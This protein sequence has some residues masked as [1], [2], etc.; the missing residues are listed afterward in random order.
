[1]ALLSCW[2][3]RP[4]SVR[5]QV[6]DTPLETSTRN[7]ASYMYDLANAVRWKFVPLCWRANEA[8]STSECECESE[9][10]G[11]RA[12]NTHRVLED[13]L[14]SQFVRGFGCGKSAAP[15]YTILPLM[16]ELHPIAFLLYLQ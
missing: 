10:Q 14:D 15:A 5:G 6:Y 4:D 3:S 12:F 1:M 11:V 13:H 2:P 16:L 8:R 7:N 9:S